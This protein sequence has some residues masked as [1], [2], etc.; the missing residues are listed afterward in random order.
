M[1][2][3]KNNITV[4]ILKK[5]SQVRI[6]QLF[7]LLPLLIVIS[8][9]TSVSAQTANYFIYPD[10]F[11]FK[12]FRS[13]VG[14]S[15]SDLPE[16]MVEEGSDFIRGPLFNAQALFGLPENFQ[17]YG[18]FYTNF[19][20][21]HFSLGPKWNHQ[22]NR[23]AF[24]IGYDIAYWFGTLNQ[25]GFKSKVNGWIHYPN[26]TLG[27]D[28]KKFAISIKTEAIIQTGRTEK[29][30]DV[31]VSS[32]LNTFA[33]VIIGIYVEQPLWKDQYLLLGLKSNITKF[34]YPIWAA[35]PTFNRYFYIP[36]FVVGFNL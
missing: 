15:L 14:L 11:A 16:D 35:F 4:M 31:E 33:G 8:G 22:I 27:Y 23:F 30:D 3:T 7:L 20:T 21:Y 34:Y 26:I 1:L 18:G 6:L 5:I 19:I 36:E 17:I 2:T 25:F 28:F 13:T 10:H 29:A 24:A 12:Q 9:T 32:S